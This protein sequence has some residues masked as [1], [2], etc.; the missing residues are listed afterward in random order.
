MARTT[1]T[2]TLYLLLPPRT[3]VQRTPPATVADLSQWPLLYAWTLRTRLQRTDRATLA[4]LAPLA[5]QAARVV[6]LLAASDVTLLRMAVPPLPAARLQAALPALVEDRVIGDPEDCAIAAG[7]ELDGR[8][9]IAITDRAW[10]QQWLTALRQAGAARITALPMQLCLPLPAGQASAALLDLSGPLELVLRTS[11]DEGLGLPVDADSPAAL[12][13]A[14]QSA[15]TTLAGARA[16]QMSVTPAHAALFH[17]WL[18]E[19]PDSGITLVDESW[20]HWVDGANQVGVD[21]AASVALRNDEQP[22]WRRWRWPLRLALACVLLNVVALNA[23]W[24]RLRSEGQAVEDDIA[25]SYR[26]VFPAEPPPV[27]PLAQM[28][29]KVAAMRQAAGEFA[30]GDF[31]TLSATLGEA[32]NE[33]GNDKRAIAGLDYRDATL[34]VRLRPGAQISLEAMAVP[35]AARR[36]SVTPSP[37]DPSLWQVRSAP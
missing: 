3:V 8:R 5:A 16:V 37:A 7:P 13:D 1:P 6:L 11:A 32:W 27:Q 2:A 14:V 12:I 18:H 26:R 23:D 17:A 35:L 20:E 29:Q 10:L 9:T 4:G 22:D 19:H 36:L 28:R 24:W 34:T 30:A 21:L 33:A 15:L 25:A 31:L